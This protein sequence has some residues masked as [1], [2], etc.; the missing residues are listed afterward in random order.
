MSVLPF[1]SVAEAKPNLATRRFGLRAILVWHLVYND[2]Y[3][4]SPALNHKTKAGQAIIRFQS[5]F[6]VFLSLITP[7]NSVA[8]IFLMEYKGFSQEKSNSSPAPSWS[9]PRVPGS[10]SPDTSFNHVSDFFRYVSSRFHQLQG[11]L[12]TIGHDLL[13]NS[14]H[15]SVPGSYETSQQGAALQSIYTSSGA[16]TTPAGSIPI[17]FIDYSSSSSGP[18]DKQSRGVSARDDSN[19]G[20]TNMH[21]VCFNHLVVQKGLPVS[22]TSFLRC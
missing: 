15:P 20:T 4:C 22:E 18:D 2:L 21:L 11:R 5:H 14:T 8:S 13:K 17:E 19:L 1:N 7:Q 6:H 3:C 12:T 10:C 9:E 16:V